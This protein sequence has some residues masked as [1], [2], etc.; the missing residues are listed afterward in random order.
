MIWL[1]NLHIYGRI[2]LIKQKSL[3]SAELK[4]KSKGPVTCVDLGNLNKKFPGRSLRSFYSKD[5]AVY[6]GRTFFS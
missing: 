5:P 2:D 3:I 4:E 1:I 6:N